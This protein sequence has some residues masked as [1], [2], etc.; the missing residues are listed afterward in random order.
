[1]KRLKSFG[2]TSLLGG[3]T[4]L[5]PIGIFLA[6]AGW[7]FG[8]IKAVI[9]PLTSLLT[10]H[11]E[12]RELFAV[13]IVLAIMVLACFFTGVVVRTQVGRWLHGTLEARLLKAL[14]GYRLIK[15][16]VLQFL[17]KRETPFSTVALVKPFGDAMMTGFVTDRHDNGWY[18]VFVPTGPNPTSGNI[19]HL[20][21]QK[22]QL[23]DAP[24]E[25]TMR[26]VIACGAGS[27][28]LLA[29][30]DQAPEL[31]PLAERAATG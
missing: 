20:P 23:I 2:V 5:L 19:F 14:P 12:L 6:V 4:V 18:S 22:V 25:D 29:Q 28:A 15:E 9:R 17:G 13:L 1:M 8:V 31:K 26:T 11:T 7:V 16:T 30:A 3:L 10:R 21:P 24:I 27:G